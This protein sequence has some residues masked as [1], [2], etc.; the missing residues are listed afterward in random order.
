MTRLKDVDYTIIFELMKNS[1]ISD[2][3]LA[4]KIGVSQPTISRRRAKLEKE[5]YFDYT[6]IPDLKKLG[7]RIMAFSFSKWTPEAATELLSEEE[8]GKQVQ[9]FFSIYPNVI[10]ATTGGSGLGGMD[11]ASISVHKDYDDYAKFVKEIK[12]EWGK[13]VSTF[14]SFMFSLTSGDLIR[15]ITFK[16]L[17][18]Y[19]DKNR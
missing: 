14:E 19:I 3:K 9:K 7:F 11:S 2:R 1:K 18:E 17:A 15:P 13:N 8:F 16:Y 5:G 12:K 4:E 6:A 10:F